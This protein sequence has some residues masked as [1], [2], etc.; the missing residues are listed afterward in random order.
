MSTKSSPLGRQI[1]EIKFQKVGKQVT[2]AVVAEFHLFS[3]HGV[4]PLRLSPT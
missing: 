1:H 2:P 3:A 4:H